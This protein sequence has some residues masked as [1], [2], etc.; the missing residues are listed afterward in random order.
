MR[1]YTC[2]QSIYSYGPVESPD[3]G[4]FAWGSLYVLCKEV[5]LLKWGGG[6]GGGKNIL[7]CSR[8]YCM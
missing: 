8:E 2:M 5:V 6:G 3:K 1:I 7:E 4:H